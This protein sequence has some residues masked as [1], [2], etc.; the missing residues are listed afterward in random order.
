MYAIVEPLS[1]CPA[2]SRAMKVGLTA[3]S[4][5]GG[6]S[7]ASGNHIFHGHAEQRVPHGYTSKNIRAWSGCCRQGGA[8]PGRWRAGTAASGARARP[9]ARGVLRGV[10]GTWGIWA[11]DAHGGEAPSPGGAAQVA[12]RGRRPS[13]GS[14]PPDLFASSA[15]PIP[16]WSSRWP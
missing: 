8:A 3:D 16:H 13:C 6:T 5:G 11:C 7:S 2:S 1:Q 15:S 14:A 9:D 12:V 4:F 10:M